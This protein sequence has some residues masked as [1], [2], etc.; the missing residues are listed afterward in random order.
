MLLSLLLLAGALQDP[1]EFQR[2]TDRE[3]VGRLLPPQVEVEKIDGR[4]WYTVRARNASAEAVL[5][6]LA[7]LSGRHLEGMDSLERSALI[8]TELEQRPLSQVL[9]FTLGSL[10]LRYELRR[11]AIVVRER[12]PAPDEALD[13]ASASWLRAWTRFPDHP[14][15]PSARLAQGEIAELRGLSAAARDHYI[16]LSEDYPRCELVGEA[17]MRAGRITARMGLW[18]E[19]AQLF[20]ELAGND[21]AAEY[22]APARLEWARAMIELGDPEAASHMLTALARDYPP[23]NDTERTARVLVEAQA[24]NARER[25]LD[26]MRAIDGLGDG[27]DAFGARQALLIRA[28]ALEG[29]GLPGEAARAW[30]VLAEDASPTE[31]RTAFEQAARLSL[32]DGDELATLFV[33]KQ[34]EQAGVRG[35]EVFAQEARARLGL[36]TPGDEPTAEERLTQAEDWLEKGDADSATI[37]IEPLFMGRG[38]MPD[39]MATRVCVAWAR[40]LEKTAGLGPAIDA[41]AEVRPEFE[42]QEARR[43]IDIGAA[44][45]FELHGRYDD[46][47]EAYRGRYAQP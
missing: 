16:A 3:D 1:F 25:H 18:S 12:E 40:C 44:D 17:L 9:E 8:T 13:Q 31:A 22:H 26:A 35:L 14:A 20:R 4:T 21:H 34:A 28:R 23:K 10:G 32:D 42:D 24:L 15:A 45:L 11:D 19:A 2:G 41:L 33:T 39:R 46:A 38:A 29:V 43:A 47:V 37:V 7:T 36:G 6:R 30:L 5:S 27:L